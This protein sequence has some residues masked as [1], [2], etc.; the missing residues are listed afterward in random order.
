M[1]SYASVAARW[2]LGASAHPGGASLTRYAARLA[3]VNA[4]SFVLD[5]AGGVGS[6]A[7]LLRAE[8]RASV[9]NVDI[10]ARSARAARARGVLTVRGDALELPVRDAA[11]DVVLCE[12]AMS[13]FPAP[14]RAVAEMA[15]ALAP[16][17]RLILTDVVAEL[18]L[19]RAHPAVDA[20]VRRLSAPL[21]AVGY[22]DLIA[23]ARLELVSQEA[24]PDDA[25][26]VIDRLLKRLRPLAAVPA[27]H[28]LRT[29]LREAR[30]A[31]DEGS[32]GY[33]LL[34]ASK[35]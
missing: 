20:G 30:T 6:S 15:R 28:R 14:S 10:E 27:V 22:A 34:I 29:T 31:V 19:R 32:L 4:Q 12:C 17:G 23:R 26:E 3:N 5:V 18:D 8:M 13:T 1:S 35:P 21:P 2:L 16:G 11:V 33:T 7:D 25:R 24:R 9:I